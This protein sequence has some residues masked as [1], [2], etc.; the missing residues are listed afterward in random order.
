[1]NKEEI[2]KTVYKKKNVISA[3]TDGAYEATYEA[4]EQYARQEYD[5][6][7]FDGVEMVRKSLTSNQQEEKP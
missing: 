4:M 5:R 7:L 6:G 2:L 3:M 1:M